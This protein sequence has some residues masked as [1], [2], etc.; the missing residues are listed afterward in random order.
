[1]RNLT[2]SKQI[3]SVAVVLAAFKKG[4]N[5][6]IYFAAGTY[7]RDGRVS[8]RFP[9]GKGI[10]GETV[11]NTISRESR[12]ELLEGGASMFF[13]RTEP[14]LKMVL[15]DENSKDKFH[16][17]ICFLVGVKGDIRQHRLVETVVGEDKKEARPEE[18]LGPLEWIE[19]EELF[20]L[21]NFARESK[22]ARINNVNCR[23]PIAHKK[24]LIAS[25]LE[26]FKESRQIVKRY[27]GLVFC[28][29]LG[30]PNFSPDSLSEESKE[31][32]RDY[33][34]SH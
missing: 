22:S 27:E 4:Q 3:G 28:G 25:L 29:D 26:I 14:V 18:H 30:N 23:A 32:I 10:A 6:E 34:K 1:M 2:D 11:A 12:Q 8:Y 19:C 20:G 13:E 24:A 16:L 17:K 9:A 7:E 21:M 5:G 33:L 15:G 31:A